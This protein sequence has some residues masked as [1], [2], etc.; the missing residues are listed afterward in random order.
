MTI[1]I[2][3]YIDLMH[4][5][6]DTLDGYHANELG[7]VTANEP[8]IVTTTGTVTG[9]DTS[10]WVDGTELTNTTIRNSIGSQ[11]S[12]AVGDMT[13]CYDG[14]T[15]RLDIKDN[16]TPLESANLC[17]LL[18]QGM[19]GC[20]GYNYDYISHIKEKSLE[21]HFDINDPNEVK[22]PDEINDLCSMD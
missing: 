5:H 19:S 12:Y 17:V 3:D 14:V 8:P 22:I 15:A 11:P 9:I 1:N 18:M 6:V 16:I 10:L 20:H 13:Y 21:R 7:T 4:T 2:S